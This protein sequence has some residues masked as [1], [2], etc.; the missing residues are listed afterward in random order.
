LTDLELLR[1]I[2]IELLGWAGVSIDGDGVTGH[3]PGI[4]TFAPPRLPHWDQDPETIQRIE[5][6]IRGR[7]LWSPYQKAI[8]SFYAAAARARCEA[9][10]AIT[11]R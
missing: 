1:A 7:G 6:A 5:D 3:V 8:P 4:F 10:L 9:A 2:A 11:R